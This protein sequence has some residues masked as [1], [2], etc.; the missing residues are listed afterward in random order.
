MSPISLTQ[1]RL[2]ELLHYDPATGEFTWLT[3]RGGKA[4]AGSRAGTDDKDGYRQISVDGRLYKAHRLAWLYMTGKWPPGDTDHRNNTPGDNIWKNL[5]T[6]T[7]SRNNQNSKPRGTSRHKGV[8]WDEKSKKWRSQ[9]RTGGKNHN[10]GLHVTEQAAAGA[11]ATFAA[12][13]FPE[14]ARLT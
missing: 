2:K 6:A 11:Y 12:K 8:S 7:R 9:V 4:R 1:S 10:L 3:W 5:R 13:H 14:F